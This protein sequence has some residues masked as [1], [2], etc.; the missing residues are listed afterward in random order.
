[1]A[2]CYT[3]CRLTLSF[4]PS[5]RVYSML[6][7]SDRAAPDHSFS[8]FA[9][10]S[11]TYPVFSLISLTVSFSALVWNTLPL[12][13]S[14]C[15]RCSVTSLPATSIRLMLFGMAKPWNTGTAC[16]TPSPQS[17]TMP[18]VFPDAYSERTAWTEAYKAG[19]LKVSNRICAAVSRFS[20][21]FSG[22]SVSSTGC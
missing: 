15:C 6:L 5:G 21:G 13:R 9:G 16:D 12:F 8:S 19:T 10:S 1:M 2:T 3:A 4:C 11:A 22:G 18:V 7:L 14:N 20:R 17:K